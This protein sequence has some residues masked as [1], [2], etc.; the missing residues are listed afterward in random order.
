[1]LGI[2]ASV[3]SESL[4]L[5][6]R[7]RSS[8]ELVA[9]ALARS[10]HRN[11]DK[12]KLSATEF[13]SITPLLLQSGAGALAWWR[14]RDS[15]PPPEFDAEELHQAYRLHSIQAAVHETNIKQA[16]KLFRDAGVEP[17]LVKGWAIARHYPEIGLRPYGDIDLCVRPDQYDL[18]KVALHDAGDR[19]PVDLH[20]GMSLLDDRSWTEVFARSQ[21][22]VLDETEVRV[23]APEDQLRVLCFHLLRHGVERPIGLCDIAVALESRAS[24]FDWKTCLGS[25]RKRADWIA[26]VI[27]LAKQLLDTDVGR[28]PFSIREHQPAW[29]VRCV[30]KSWGQNFSNHFTQ[31]APMAFYRHHPRGLARAL[32]ARW[33]TPIMGTVGVGG[34]FNS[35]PRF[36][37]QLGYLLLRSAR[38]LKHQS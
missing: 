10:W 30:L 29:I 20:K 24:D 14:L 33:P 3:N 31:A 19:L 1:M 27:G 25:D 38:F 15:S 7:A 35:L 17:I 4:A 32:A 8:G 18:A 22:A 9:A 16:L 34:S 37:Y 23:L 12:A 21:L 26:C 13:A 2:H 36:P 6:Q 5:N 28:L 11:P